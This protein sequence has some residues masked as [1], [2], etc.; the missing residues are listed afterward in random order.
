MSSRAPLTPEG[1]DVAALEAIFAQRKPRLY[2]TIAGLHN[3]TG[4]SLSP[5]AAHRVLKLAERH[6][7]VIVE[8]E[9]FADF[10]PGAPGTR[11]AAF[12]GLDRVI[13]VGSYSKTVSAALRCGYIALQARLGRGDRRSQTRDRAEQRPFRRRL[14]ASGAHRSRLSPPSDRAEGAARRCDGPDAAPAES[15]RPDAMDRAARRHLRLG[16]AARRA[17]RDRGR[18]ARPRRGRR[19][20]ARRG[21]QRLARSAK[22]S[23]L[24]R[25]G[26]SQPVRASPRSRGRW[27]S[28]RAARG[29]VEPFG[30]H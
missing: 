8:D 16:A 17:R 19:L 14:S 2:L 15:E 4:A 29:P 12:D 10:E 25:G 5:A 3:P 23:A 21:V 13:Q 6:D 11:L 7:V 9:I 1:P 24:Q 26:E 20:R 22:P 18:A 28:P 27:R 30:E